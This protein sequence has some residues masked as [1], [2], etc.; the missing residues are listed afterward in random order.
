VWG[1]PHQ[2]DFL[3]GNLFSGFEN[4]ITLSANL[5]LLELLSILKLIKFL[6]ETLPII[7]CIDC[8]IFV[9]FSGAIGRSRGD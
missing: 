1:I 8:Q 9:H 6:A 3:S 2:L 4:L 5:R 7:Q